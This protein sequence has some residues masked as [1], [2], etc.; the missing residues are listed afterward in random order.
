[1]RIASADENDRTDSPVTRCEGRPLRVCQVMKMVGDAEI[2]L[3]IPA[4]RKD[5]GDPKFPCEAKRG[6]PHHL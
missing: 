6:A 4:I 3:Q 5:G 1:M 2:T